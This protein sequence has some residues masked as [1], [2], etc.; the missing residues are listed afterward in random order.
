MRLRA[1]LAKAAAHYEGDMAA[2]RDAFLQYGDYILQNV[3]GIDGGADGEGVAAGESAA[4]GSSGTAEAELQEALELWGE[5]QLKNDVSE[6]CFASMNME[7]GLVL[8]EL[9]LL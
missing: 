6:G 8:S 7:I 4:A 3:A 1:Q 2:Y 5:S 9:A